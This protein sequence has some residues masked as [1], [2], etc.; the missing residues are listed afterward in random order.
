MKTYHVKHYILA[1]C[2]ASLADVASAEKLKLQIIGTLN[3]SVELVASKLETPD[4]VRIEITYND[5]HRS[6]CEVSS[7]SRTSFRCYAEISGDWDDVVLS[8]RSL[9]YETYILR[10]PL[11]KSGALVDVGKIDL[12]PMQQDLVIIDISRDRG[13][14]FDFKLRNVG[15]QPVFIKGI[16]FLFYP[17]SGIYSVCMYEWFTLY[18]Y[19]L[20]A[21]F[22]EQ[23]INV[24]A[25]EQLAKDYV[26]PGTKANDKLYINMFG[27]GYRH[28][29]L[30]TAMLAVS[31]V[32]P[33]NDVDRFKIRFEVDQEY[34]KGAREGCGWTEIYA[35][36]AIIHYD[37][38]QLI[39]PKFQVEYSPMRLAPDSI[40]P[41]RGR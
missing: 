12:E 35:A 10:I 15:K 30:K 19:P 18:D 31:Q 36:N 21:L 13:L 20:S 9:Q 22:G 3:E 38:K 8:V 24:A 33:P 17:G 11:P 14:S 39:S 1:L 7:Q 6:I 5:S 28:P 26:I 41:E 32:I 16:Q 34:A 37:D 27:S 29:A 40:Q 4:Q 25:G 2:V 23:K